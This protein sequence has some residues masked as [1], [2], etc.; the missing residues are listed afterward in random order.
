ML[1]ALASPALAE[2]LPVPKLGAVPDRLPAE[3]RQPVRMVVTTREAIP[4][5]NC[6]IGESR[7]N[8]HSITQSELTKR[9]KACIDAIAT[10]ISAQ[11]IGLAY[12]RPES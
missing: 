5:H 8:K 9:L 2:P 10:T 7:M 12:H 6:R 3:R 1:F 4:K 11:S